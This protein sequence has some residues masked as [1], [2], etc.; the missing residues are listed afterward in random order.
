MKPMKSFSLTLSNFGIE[1]VKTNPVVRL[2]QRKFDGPNKVRFFTSRPDSLVKDLSRALGG[3]VEEYQK[4]MGIQ[5]A[6]EKARVEL[7]KM[8]A[9]QKALLKRKINAMIKEAK[10]NGITF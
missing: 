4:Q 1:T 5:T 2:Y 9:N 10:L 3:T 7:E 6:D 8:N